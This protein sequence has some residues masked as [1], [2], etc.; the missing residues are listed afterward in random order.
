MPV[1]LH[2]SEATRNRALM[3]VPAFLSTLSTF[4]DGDTVIRAAIDGP[5]APFNVIAS[6]LWKVNSGHLD[7][8]GSYGHTSAE[9]EQWQHQPLANATPSAECAR[10]GQILVYSEDTVLETFPDLT[11]I[12]IS[13][14]D[15][16]TFVFGK[17]P[18]RYGFA[19]EVVLAPIQ[20]SGI[21]R[22]VFGFITDARN[23]WSTH[24][25][26]LISTIC[27]GIAL[28][29]TNPQTPETPDDRQYILTNRQLHILS[30]VA[31]GRSSA[32]I[33][34]H[35]GY[36]LSTINQELQRIN[37]EFRV[38]DRM[39]AVRIAREVGLIS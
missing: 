28:W 19:G 38:H 21:P 16:R 36:S 7:I 20:A 25:Y 22:G 17:D 34:A 30:L 29:M 24:T 1:R 33:A 37:A 6:L 26:S 2:P 23:E 5:L 14:E 31:A 3:G 27:S 4:P 18:H 8:L 35:M 9:L 15:L 32:Y 39:S 13:T 11:H 12:E 10:E